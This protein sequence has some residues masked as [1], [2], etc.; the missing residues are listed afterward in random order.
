M[1]CN[2]APSRPEQECR[3]RVIARWNAVRHGVGR[4]KPCAVPAIQRSTM[5]LP[6]LRKACSGLRG[7]N[8]SAAA[9]SLLD[10][11]QL[12]TA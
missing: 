7:W 1:E 12:G 10:G 9:E 5:Q 4:N 2:W 6:E 3:R 8:K 11:M